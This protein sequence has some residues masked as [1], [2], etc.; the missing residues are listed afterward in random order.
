MAIEDKEKWNKKYKNTPELLASRPQSY[1]LSNVINYAK[2]LNALDVACGSGRNSIF[3]ANNGFN[4]TSIDISEVALNSL[5]EKNNPKIKTQLV[6]LDT[7]KFDENS[8]DLIIMTN[9]LDRKAIPKL[10]NA[11]KKDGVLFIE[12]YMFH[13]E[14]EKPPSNPDFLLKEGELKNF[15]DEKEVE[16]IEYDEFFNESFELYK[17]RKQAIAIRKK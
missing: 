13:E 8:Y 11:L 4:V 12:T 16:I 2:G 3:L 10:V 1:K 9:F 7:H 14:N 17:M 5:N 6:D 15:F